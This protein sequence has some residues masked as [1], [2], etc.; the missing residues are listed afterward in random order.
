[1]KNKKSKTKLIKDTPYEIEWTDTFGFNGWFTN[2]EID[3][4][5]KHPSIAKYVGYFIKEDNGFIILA[6][7]RETNRDDF[8]PYSTI[9]WIPKGYIRSIKRLKNN[10]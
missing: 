10:A 8:A 2:E 6:M 4:K 3:D 9:K 5:T 1:M 7:G